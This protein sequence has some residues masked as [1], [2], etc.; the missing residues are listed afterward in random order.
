MAAIAIEDIR[1][2]GPE[3]VA[4]RLLGL[5]KGSICVVN[6]A[7]ARDLQRIL[8]QTPVTPDQLGEQFSLF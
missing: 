1:R 6:A 3:R 5:A 2:G 8:G 4:E 7:S